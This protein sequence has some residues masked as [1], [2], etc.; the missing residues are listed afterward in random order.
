MR[1]PQLSA[2]DNDHS[3]EV[4]T[5]ATARPDADDAEDE[6]DVAELIEQVGS[7]RPGRRGRRARPTTT[8]GAIR[9]SRP[10]SNSRRTT[11]RGRQSECEL[12]ATIV[13]AVAT[14][15]AT[16]MTRPSPLSLRKNR[17]SPPGDLAVGVVPS[18]TGRVRPVN[19]GASEWPGTAVPGKQ[20]GI[21]ACCN[22]AASRPC[23]THDR[24]RPSDE[25]TRTS[26][27]NPTFPAL[28]ERILEKWDAA[29]DVPRVDPAPRGRGRR[30][31]RVLRRPAVRQRPA[32][33]R[34]PAHRLR[35]GR[36]AAL[37]DDAR[38]ARP[39]PLRLGLPRPARRGRGRA[40]AGHRRPPGDHRLRHRQ[41]QRRLPHQ[42]AALHR[43]VGALRHPPGPLGRL[44]ER[45][46][47]PRPRLHGERHVGVQDAVG[48]GPRVRGVQGAGLLLAVRDA[49][50]QH[51]DA[52]GRR[53]LR[54]SGSGAHRWLRARRRRRNGRPARCCW[55]GRR[56]RGR[57]RPTSPS[58]SARTSTTSSSTTAAS[59]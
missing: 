20:G 6:A 45:L 27:R 9:C 42:R 30:R 35:Q 56:R 33:L 52:D 14:L 7:A 47:D 44:R 23:G 15:T 57:F 50:Q 34:P 49:A 51:R 28:E 29:T 10:T 31:V 37:P 25:P 26:T 46:Q 38:Q 17:T 19:A 13:S 5:P 40:R 55:R 8:S 58:P 3:G 4:E 53:L 32:A 39:P 36:R 2:S 18:R 12:T 11:S 16:A 54:P 59:A 48:Q 22:G 24:R 1:R 41:L 21:A 43:R